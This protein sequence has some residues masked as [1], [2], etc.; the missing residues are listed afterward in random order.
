MSAKSVKRNREADIKEYLHGDHTEEELIRELSIV[1]SLHRTYNTALSV[2]AII[3]AY[4]AVFAGP[5]IKTATQDSYA[6]I[7]LLFL[8]IAIIFLLVWVLRRTE[9]TAHRETIID[10]AIEK[11]RYQ[12]SISIR[13]PA[14]GP[15]RWLSALFRH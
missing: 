10:Q 9:N 2:T 15:R 4:F 6:A 7:L 12:Q 8:T 14:K 13:C 5:V 1:R 3:V 11:K